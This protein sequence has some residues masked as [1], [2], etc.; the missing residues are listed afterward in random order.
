VLSILHAKPQLSAP[1]EQALLTLREQQL[2]WLHL[3]RMVRG[4]LLDGPR[5]VCVPA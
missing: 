5:R 4:L 3:R 1:P 2:T